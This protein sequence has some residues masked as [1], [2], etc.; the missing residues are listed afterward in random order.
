MTPVS[1]LSGSSRDTDINS[2]QTSFEFYR[3]E[4]DATG[5][6]VGFRLVMLNASAV[7]KWGKPQS[8]L[9][10]Q[11]VS[12]LMHADDADYLSGQFSLVMKSGRAVR[13]DMSHPGQRNGPSRTGELLVVKQDDGVLVSY[14]DSDEHSFIAHV[15][16][17][18]APRKVGQEKLHQGTLLQM[19][20]DSSQSGVVLYEIVHDEVSGEVVDFRFVLTNPANEQVVGRAKAELLGKSIFA[21]YPELMQTAWGEKL[22]TCARTGERQMFLFPYFKEGIN[23]WFDV[24]FVRHE[25]YI[26]L[27][28]SDVTALK[29]AEL[30]LRQQ[31]DLLKEIVE[32]GQ[33]GMTLFDPI[34]NESGEIIDFRYVFTNAVNARVMGRSVAELTGE[35]LLTLFPTRPQTEWYANLMHTATTGESRSYLYELNTDRIN[36]WFNTL[37]VKVGDQILY[38]YLDITSLKQT[39]QALQEQ[40]DLLEQVMNTTPTVIALHESVR[41]EAGELIDFRL[42]H[43][44]QKAAD[45]LGHSLE[46]GQIPLLSDYFPGVQK[47]PVF[48]HYRRVVEQSEPIRTE[49]FWKHHWYDLSAARISDGMVVVAQDI[50]P[51][52]ESQHKLEVANLELKRSNENLQSFAFVSSHDLQEPLRKII[53]FTDILQT[54]YGNQFDAE[55]TNIIHRVNTSADRM[56]LL[57]QDLLAYSKL[58]T[59]QD[60]FKPVDITTL[61]Q[62]LQEHELWVTL[63]QSKARIQLGK[64]P[65]V[66]ADPLQMRQLFQNLLSNAVKFALKDVTPVITITHQL[67]NR[68]EIP[69]DLLSPAKSGERKSAS[70]KFHE[71]SVADNGIG[72]DEKYIDRIFQVFQRLHGRSQ[73]TGSGIGLAI[74]YKI[75][76]RHGGAITASSKP[77]GGSTF[78]VYLPV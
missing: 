71:I 11:S 59:N 2:L 24:S 72:F 78:R 69:T 4:Y 5:Q 74:C 62:E 27:T 33:T 73:Y 37:F 19:I 15:V 3:A 41:N 52:K 75:V 39:K 76:E 51:M 70:P 54:Q 36:G 65:T 17:T 68:A 22:L 28:F 48:E 50:T 18:T 13:F 44:N 20:I 53:S 46:E 56:R 25:H 23:G 9:L 10:N 58:E 12:Q 49:V 40:N 21:I 7:D 66:I 32:N 38:T 42:T 45:L 30:A 8:E 61:I 43:L 55:A 47:T 67:V 14:N 64:L 29:E 26:L 31:N 35:R 63:N 57:I 6:L 34:R 16:D 77:G 60:L 1:S